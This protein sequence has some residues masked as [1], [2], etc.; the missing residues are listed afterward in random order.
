VQINKILRSAVSSRNRPNSWGKLAIMSLRIQFDR[1]RRQIEERVDQAWTM[2]WH[3]LKRKRMGPPFDG[4]PR[5]ALITVNYST[6]RYLKLML[7]TLAEQSSLKLLKR[8]ILVDNGSRDG[9]SSF[10]R[11]LAERINIISVVHNRWFLNHARG[12]RSGLRLLD[13]VEADAAATERANIVLSCDADVVFRRSDTLSDLA[14]AFV[15]EGAAL[16]GELRKHLYPYPEAQASFVAVRRDCYS[17]KDIAPWVNHGAPAYWMQRSIWRAE[18]PVVNFP[19]ND[20]GYILH[21]GRSGV[22]AAHLFFPYSS[23]A[24]IH[25][26]DAHYMG[27][28]EGARIWRVIEARWEALLLPE[29]Q[30]RLIAHLAKQF[31]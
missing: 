14:K 8:I 1:A 9:G 17:R 6:T 27:M 7:L 24:T 31:G 3:K 22:V 29:A 5:F 2:T 25:N 23:Y 18:L 4:E 16:A 10:L 19:S 12:M 15:E 28:P 20:G 21:R 11:E 13:L 30:E 26:N